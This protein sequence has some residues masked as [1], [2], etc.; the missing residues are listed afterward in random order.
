MKY[1]KIFLKKKKTRSKKKARE[2][3]KYLTKNK[4]KKSIN[5]IVNVIK[6]FLKIKNK[7]S[8]EEIIIKHIKINF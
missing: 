4:N 6:T 8:I 5:I 1:I 7:L 2:D 3:V